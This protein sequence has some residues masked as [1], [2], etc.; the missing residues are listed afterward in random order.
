MIIQSRQ[1][2]RPVGS[3]VTGLDPCIID[4]SIG[5]VPIRPIGRFLR[6]SRMSDKPSAP[7]VVQNA[8]LGG[9]AAVFRLIPRRGAL[10]AGGI[11]GRCA[12]ALVGSKR[13]RTE[14]NLDAAGVC[15]PKA[16]SRVASSGMP[17]SSRIMKSP[18]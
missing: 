15:D 11:V 5:T 17:R 6:G 8:V 18:R 2:W 14:I 13:K 10:L 12:G 3:I 16:A 7:S 4:S 9:A 1:D